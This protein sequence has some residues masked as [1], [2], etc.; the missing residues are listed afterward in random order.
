MQFG[1]GFTA[2]FLYYFASTALVFTLVTALSLDTAIAGVPQQV[3]LMG[4]LL[5]GLIGAY[6]N[7]SVSV[8]LPFKS[9]KT[10]WKQLD[11][12]LSDLGYRLREDALETE[13]T[14]EIR[15]YEREGLQKAL[16]G[17]I[18]VQLEGNT[19]TLAGRAVQVK[20]IRK[21]LD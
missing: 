11:P 2:T 13:G 10:F 21:R 1:P 15:V 8:E 20:A 5:G 3:G 6:F 18:Y 19:A 14:E 17:K 7:R 12:I 16:S 9:K 4:G